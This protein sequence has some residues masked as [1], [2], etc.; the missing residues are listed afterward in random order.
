M[1]A[2]AAHTTGDAAGSGLLGG[3]RQLRSVPRRPLRVCHVSLTLATGG[4]ERLLADIARL[5]DP[6]VCRPEFLAITQDGPFADQI[7]DAGCVADT[8]DHDL[9]GRPDSRWRHLQ[10]V[11]AMRRRFRE[12]GYDVV[13]THN[14]Y[15]HL[16]ATVA[17]RLAGIPIVINTRHGQR[18]GHGRK[19]RT[20]FRLACHWADRV[21]AVSDDAARLTIDSDGVP[22]H[23]V[24]RIWNGI[25]TRQFCLFPATRRPAT[26]VAI[27]VGRLSPGKDFE[28]M[29]EAV[30][31]ALDVVPELRLRII[32]DGPQRGELERLVRRRRI[33]DRV[34]FLG[35]RHD[36][37]R[38]LADA[39]FYVTS[40]LSEGIS[41]SLLEAMAAGLPVIAT[42]VGGTR[43]VISDATVGR[44]VPPADPRSL[45]DEIGRLWAERERW[46]TTEAAARRRVTENFDARRMTAEYERLYVQL[47]SSGGLASS[48]TPRERESQHD[49]R[50]QSAD[51]GDEDAA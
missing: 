30:T 45:A 9:P 48:Q 17:A 39:G 25:D 49:V 42:D 7:R 13:H 8:L 36:V 47:A 16:Y 44:L 15:P 19:S 41:L 33:D 4:M 20:L 37:P 51:G 1:T 29:I 50:G 14:P 2:S 22:P 28:T 43:E 21:V 18:I 38:L 24:T 6:A 5:H 10:R 23:K 34:T 35:E 32:G 12:R 11:N 40:S 31:L 26:P 3:S 46:P 27:A